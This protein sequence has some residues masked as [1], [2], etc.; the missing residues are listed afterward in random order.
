M[1]LNIENLM[2]TAIQEMQN[3]QDIE[4]SKHFDLVVINDAL[5]IDAPFFRAYCNCYNI[6]L[7]EMSNAAIGFTNAFCLYVDAVKSLNNLEIEKKKLDY[8]VTLLTSLVA[9]YHYNAKKTML[10]VPSLG[11]DISTAAANMN[12][13]CRNKLSSCGA[14]VSIEVLQNNQTQ[15]SSNSKTLRRSTVVGVICF[16]SA[17]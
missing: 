5:N 11:M 7:G 15:N 9:M 3:G 12:N 10:S 14:N 1:E 4:A 8:A 6:K 2:K 17:L 16:V 13:S